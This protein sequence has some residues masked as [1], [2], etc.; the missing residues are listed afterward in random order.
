MTRVLLACYQYFLRLYPRGF[1]IRYGRE[2][3]LFMR[4]YA[5]D[6]GGIAM[7]MFLFSDLLLSVPREHVREAN[8]QR[9]VTAAAGVLMLGLVGMQLVYDVSHPNVRSGFLMAM[10]LTTLTVAGGYLLLRRNRRYTWLIPAAYA[11]AAGIWLIVT[12]I[13]LND[14]A[15]LRPFLFSLG[16]PAAISFLFLPVFIALLP[17]LTPRQERMPTIAT[18]LM[19]AFIVM[20]TGLA[21]TYYV[22][23]AVA[24]L[25]VRFGWSHRDMEVRNA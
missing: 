25:L 18:L 1:R 7:G 16:R 11:A 12:P 4:D 17:M 19:L 5:R 8:M 21:G 22:P 14:F 10:I 24:M 23:A 2:M 6:H 9:F 13:R 20:A 3:Q 15:P